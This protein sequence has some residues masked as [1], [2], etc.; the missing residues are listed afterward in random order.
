MFFFFFI[1]Y[2]NQPDVTHIQMYCL[3]VFKEAQN[4]SSLLI[5]ELMFSITARA[6]LLLKILFLKND[7]CVVFF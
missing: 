4:K 3:F 1:S 7:A 2:Q 6:F 5:R